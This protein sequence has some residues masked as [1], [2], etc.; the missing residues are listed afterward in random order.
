MSHHLGLIYATKLGY[1]G[2][3]YEV[4]NTLQE[5]SLEKIGIPGPVQGKD[6]KQEYGSMIWG[7]DALLGLSRGRKLLSRSTAQ[8]PN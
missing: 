6:V 2:E 8:S 1:T 5:P 7:Y 3:K 4:S